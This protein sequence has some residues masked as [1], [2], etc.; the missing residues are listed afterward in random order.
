LYFV[1]KGNPKSNKLLTAFIHWVLTEGQ[2]F[3]HEAGYISLPKEKIAA[4]L[5][6]IQ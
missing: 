5:K 1:A 4:E 2:K 6:K 3:V